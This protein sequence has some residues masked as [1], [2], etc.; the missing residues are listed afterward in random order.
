LFSAIPQ[1]T[2]DPFPEP[3][4]DEIQQLE[5]F[6]R[7]NDNI[8][9]ITGAGVST[10]SG[11]PDYRGP[12]GSYNRGHKPVVHSE[13]VSSEKTRQRY[14]ARSLLGWKSFSQARPNDA[15]LALANLEMRGV[16]S[17]IVTQNVDRLHQKAGSIDVID[18]HGRNDRLSC[19]SCGYNM[20]RRIIQEVEETTEPA[21]FALFHSF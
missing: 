2:S 9:V 15:H 11:I 21:N 7:G 4:N 10:S 13:F 8:V 12:Q 3:K 14:W 17:T 6:L 5:S 18:L 1:Q 16:I 19:L 20:S